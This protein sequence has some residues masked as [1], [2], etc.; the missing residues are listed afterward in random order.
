M[1]YLPSQAALGNKGD[2]E[3]FN[4]KLQDQK[5]VEKIKGNQ[6]KCQTGIVKAQ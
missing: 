6:V 2:V 5:S 1:V 4:A 3:S